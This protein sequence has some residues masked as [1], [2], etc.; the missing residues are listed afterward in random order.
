MEDE[1]VAGVDGVVEEAD[2]SEVE[3]ADDRLVEEDV[4]A[5]LLVEDRRV[6]SAAE[7]AE[8]ASRIHSRVDATIHLSIYCHP[9]S[10]SIDTIILHAIMRKVV[11]KKPR[12]IDAV[13]RSRRMSPCRVIAKRVSATKSPSF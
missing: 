2:D 1:E 6:V 7:E 3:E 4:V 9:Y 5:D 13:R 8:V 10:K 11:S 12:F